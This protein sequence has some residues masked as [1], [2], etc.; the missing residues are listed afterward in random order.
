VLNK[1]WNKIL[2]GIVSHIRFATVTFIPKNLKILIIRNDKRYIP[3][4]EATKSKIA[5]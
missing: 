5:N 3:T 1:T 2:S 4:K